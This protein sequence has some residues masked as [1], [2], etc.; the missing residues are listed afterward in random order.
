MSHTAIMNEKLLAEPE[1][2]LF[3]NKF[4]LL[5]LSFLSQDEEYTWM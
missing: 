1:G 2:K 5:V 3:V 4:T